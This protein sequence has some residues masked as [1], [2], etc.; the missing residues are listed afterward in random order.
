MVNGAFF[1]P[2]GEGMEEI[3]DKASSTDPKSS[4]L[5][6]AL[7]QNAGVLGDPRCG[8]PALPS[9]R[10]LSPFARPL[11]LPP[12]SMAFVHARVGKVDRWC[13]RRRHVDGAGA[14]RCRVS[15]GLSLI[16]YWGWEIS[17]E[18][19]P[20]G[21]LFAGAWARAG[22]FGLLVVRL[23]I[24]RA[25]LLTSSDGATGRRTVGPPCSPA[26]FA[27]HRSARE[28]FPADLAAPPLFSVQ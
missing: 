21:Y 23:L 28:R 22:R 5:V 2:S 15:V 8:A 13:P 1:V 12:C 7:T 4:A 9:P 20:T 16:S 6:D 11:F 27:A 10:E 24:T 17:R 25:L 18:T 14:L 26:R 19:G 3:Y